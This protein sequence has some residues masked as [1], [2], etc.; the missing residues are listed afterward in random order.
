MRERSNFHADVST[1][2]G[3]V[4]VGWTIDTH[5]TRL[6]TLGALRFDQQLDNFFE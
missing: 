4:L 5:D 1:A 2:V 3:G 6:K